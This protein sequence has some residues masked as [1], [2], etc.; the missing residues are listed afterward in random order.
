MLKMKMVMRPARE[1]PL[2]TLTCSHTLF[3]RHQGQ[4]VENEH[5][6]NIM[7]QFY[8]RHKSQVVSVCILYPEAAKAIH[9]KKC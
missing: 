6:L 8:I 3:S 4:V 1:S 5:K 9:V 7:S 2:Y